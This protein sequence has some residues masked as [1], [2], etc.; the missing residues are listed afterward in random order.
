MG[1]NA[2]GSKTSSW[3]GTGNGLIGTN[4]KES[5]NEKATDQ[6]DHQVEVRVVLF[7]ATTF[8]AH[9]VIRRA[10]AKGRIITGLFF[11]LTITLQLILETLQLV[12]ENGIEPLY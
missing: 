7:Q 5:A 12:E 11:Y 6:L 10:G 3:C 4:G 8:Q 9:P 1:A 2:R